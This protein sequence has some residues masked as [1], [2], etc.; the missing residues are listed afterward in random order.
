M[1]IELKEAGI[2]VKLVVRAEK[3]IIC[4]NQCLNLVIKE[5][6][7]VKTKNPRARI[8]KYLQSP[9]NTLKILERERERKKKCINFP[10]MIKLKLKPDVHATREVSF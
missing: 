7:S 8:Q 10:K 3:A 1:Q 4:Q 2:N 5:N 9:F 6:V